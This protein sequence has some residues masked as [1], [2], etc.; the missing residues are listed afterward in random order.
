M[1]VAT[2]S[3]GQSD[4]KN[5]QP[6][7]TLGEDVLAREAV[8]LTRDLVTPRPWIYWLDLTASA[9]AGYA[10]LFGAMIAGSAGMVIMFGIVSVLSLYRAGSFIHELAHIATMV[11]GFRT[12]W[13]LIVGVPML[14]PSFMYEGVHSIHH[15]RRRYGTAEDPE[16]LPLA[17][18]RPA[19]LAVFLGL[20]AFAPIILL[21]RFGILAPLSALSGR[22]RAVVVTRYSALAINPEFRRKPPEAAFARSW[23]IW[24]AATCAW[25]IALIV[26]TASGVI[27]VRAFAT[28]IAVG[29]SVALINQVRT[30]VAHLWENDGSE[31][32]ATGQYLDT[33]NVPPP[34][35]LPELWAPVGLRYHAL[36]HLLPGLP[37]HALG[38]AHRRLAT[39]FEEASEYHRAS[40]PGLPQLVVKLV[41][42][43][44]GT[45]KFEGTR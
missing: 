6:R 32:T 27:P 42:A 15:T 39:H 1:N 30:L 33:V 11:R 28:F 24:E 44:G 8:R 29:S 41:R 14:V 36:H 34:G 21:V 40:H 2:A 3:A 23:L 18:M 43:S 25:A 16:Y 20:A 7:R 38:N 12:F 9:T 5:L 10:A 19:A 37:Y 17:L 22:L 45:R 13:N 35:F 26:G 31:L 4:A